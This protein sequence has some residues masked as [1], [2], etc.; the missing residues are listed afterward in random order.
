[1]LPPWSPVLAPGL[2]CLEYWVSS[3]AHS[4]K[5]TTSPDPVG[6]H[7]NLPQT[8]LVLASEKPQEFPLTA[9][10]TPLRDL[11][12]TGGGWGQGDS[13]IC[14]IYQRKPTAQGER[15]G[16][17]LQV[18]PQTSGLGP[19][20]PLCLNPPQSGSRLES[21]SPGTIWAVALFFNQLP[22]PHPTFT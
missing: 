18:T 15:P 14:P 5:L 2:A 11:L 19:G 4:F 1:M 8:W 10:L 20:I 17:L 12:E 22:V 21:Q 6:Y 3:F 9:R 7:S 13:R 16:D